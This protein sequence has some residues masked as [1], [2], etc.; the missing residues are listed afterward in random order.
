MRFVEKRERQF[1]ELD[2]NMGTET[3]PVT[4]PWEWSETSAY[5]M[6]RLV[7]AHD[8]TGACKKNRFGF[9]CS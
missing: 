6:Y 1:D 9:F 5:I 7:H 8:N 3:E 2:G 4:L